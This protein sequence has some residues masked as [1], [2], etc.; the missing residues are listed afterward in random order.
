MEQENMEF[1]LELRFKDES[2][3]KLEN[4]KSEELFQRI[5]ASS[6]DFSHS[7]DLIEQYIER[8]KHQKVNE[9]IK[10]LVTDGKYKVE[11]WFRLVST[12]IK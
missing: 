3:I 12:R 5:E 8:M 7:K 9:T 2:T 10:L 6:Q 1:A 4:V 11:N